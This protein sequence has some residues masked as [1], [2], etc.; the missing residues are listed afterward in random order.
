M[1]KKEL[2]QAVKVVIEEKTG[3]I[4]TNVKAED[5]YETIIGI[6]TKELLTEKE[7]TIVGVGKLTV[8][9]RAERKGWNPA[10]Q[11]EILI[12]AKNAVTFRSAKALKDQ[13]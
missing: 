3:I 1:T 8:K 5:I 2:I 12:P 4:C 9:E 11:E 10:K 7:T 6:H 13:I